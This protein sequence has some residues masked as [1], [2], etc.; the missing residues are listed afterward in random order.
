MKVRN[1]F[2]SGNIISAFWIP[3]IVDLKRRVNCLPLKLPF[4]KLSGILVK[5]A[6]VHFK[7]ITQIQNYFCSRGDLTR[8]NY[9]YS[10]Y[11][12][13]ILRQFL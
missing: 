9:W 11:T 2:G 1:V 12:I 10:S 3:M 8:Y 7:I 5:I 13:Y 4:K 6:T